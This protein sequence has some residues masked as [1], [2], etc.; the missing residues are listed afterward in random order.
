MEWVDIVQS[1]GFPIVACWA[2]WKSNEKNAEAHKAETDELR[3]AIE[4]NTLVMTRLCERLK[5]DTS[6]VAAND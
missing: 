5:L 3:K 1:V 2:L 6:E 4:N